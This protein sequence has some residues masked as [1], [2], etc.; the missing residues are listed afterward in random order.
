[1]DHLFFFSCVCW[2][3]EKKVC[4]NVRKLSGYGRVK[5]S[6]D[7]WMDKIYVT[8][9][10]ACDKMKSDKKILLEVISFNL[11]SEGAK[12]SRNFVDCRETKL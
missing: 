6:P 2:C 10:W 7:I 8:Q 9:W 12:I 11:D 3:G 1:M 4:V 5:A